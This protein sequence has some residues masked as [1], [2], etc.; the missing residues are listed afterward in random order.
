MRTCKG[1]PK[2]CGTCERCRALESADILIQSGY[3]QDDLHGHRQGGNPQ[4]E[5][6]GRI[7]RFWLEDDEKV[8]P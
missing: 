3:A 4:R 6:A 5:E 2:S 7:R 8:D 1:K